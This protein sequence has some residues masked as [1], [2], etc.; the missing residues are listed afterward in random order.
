MNSILFIILC[1][2]IPIAIAFIIVIIIG[3]F[4]KAIIHKKYDKLTEIYLFFDEHANW[5]IY[6]NLKKQYQLGNKPVLLDNTEFARAMARK[7]SV[8]DNYYITILQGDFTLWQAI[9]NSNYKII[10]TGIYSN[11]ILKLI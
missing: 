3:Y 7:E 5:K 4:Y 1:F 10:L 2:I 11:L 6:K 8:S 9:D